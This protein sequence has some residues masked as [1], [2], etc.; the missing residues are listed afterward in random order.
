MNISKQLMK[1]Y[2]LIPSLMA[3]VLL[4]L[5]YLLIP[6]VIRNSHTVAFRANANAVKRVLLDSNSSSPCLM[7]FPDS[8]QIVNRESPQQFS[9]S[10]TGRLPTTLLIKAES[11]QLDAA[12]A[13]HILPAGPDSVWLEWIS[14]VPTSYNPL[15]RWLAWRKAKALSREMQ[16]ELE[17]LRVC[18]SESRRLYGFSIQEERV[19]DSLLVSTSVSGKQEADI[20]TVYQL[21]DELRAFIQKHGAVA[22][23]HPMLNYTRTDSNFIT[24]VAIPVNKRLPSEGRIAWRWMLGGGRI[25]VTEV[26]G[27]PS[28]VRQAFHEMENYVRD[29]GRTPPAIPFYS[30]VTDRRAVSDTN[31]WVT[32]IYYPVM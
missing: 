28:R 11:R 3:L 29:H 12:T 23:G 13:L 6:S 24:R 21:I 31:Q 27:G 18:L 19:Q 30:L 5:I 20:A 4:L 16:T 10:I 2:W 7:N 32:K 17:N 1:K 26:E 15:K 25:L 8:G 22:T 14:Q 9:Y